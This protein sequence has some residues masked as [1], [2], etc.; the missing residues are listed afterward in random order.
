MTQINLRWLAGFT[1]VYLLLLPTNHGTYLRSLAF[2]GAMFFAACAVGWSLWEGRRLPDARIPLPPWSV[3]LT[4][5][6]WFAW[7]ALSY[8]WS[9][10]H[11]YPAGQLVREGAE[12]AL[13][14]IA[15][16]I[17]SCDRVIFRRFA[18]T[19]LASFV[20]MAT[21]AIVYAMT[22]GGWDPTQKHNGVGPYSTYV[23]LTAP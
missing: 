8:F 3:T 19:A 18:A 6:A 2:G 14:V 22:P 11:H 15:F 17:A 20:I 13:L 23:V 5:A 10:K 21:L 1:G 12:N 4:V 16:Y 7:S 9:V